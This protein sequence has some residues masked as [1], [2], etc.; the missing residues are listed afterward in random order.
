MLRTF[1]EPKLRGLWCPNLWFQQDCA[2]A[3][4]SDLAPCDYFLWG[5]LKAEV[6]KH[7][8][9]AIE[10]LKDAISQT[11]AEVSP[12]MTLRVTKICGN[13]LQLCMANRHPHLEDVIFETE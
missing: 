5:Y 7:R 8:P 9:A 3:R 10:E 4:S 12:E 1:L 11:V 13:R 2:T 6:H